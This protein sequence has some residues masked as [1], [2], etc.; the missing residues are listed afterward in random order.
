MEG[1][2]AAPK[3]RS[4]LT[5]I[6]VTDLHKK[7]RARVR[8][9][10]LARLRWIACP[11]HT[12]CTCRD[13]NVVVGIPTPRLNSNVPVTTESIKGLPGPEKKQKIEAAIKEL[14]TKSVH[15]SPRG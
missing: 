8:A 6:S 3:P 11:R 5:Q 4:P 13:R 9:G 12:R 10:A 2:G 7:L 1:G 14:E 15:R